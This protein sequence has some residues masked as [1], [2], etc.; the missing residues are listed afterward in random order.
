MSEHVKEKKSA[1]PE[2]IF[3][4]ITD[5]EKL[6]EMINRYVGGP[7]CLVLR[8][9]GISEEQFLNQFKCRFFN[10][11]KP[12]GEDGTYGIRHLLLITGPSIDYYLAI[13]ANFG[14]DIA[15]FV[16]SEKAF[17]LT[18]R[19]EV[20]EPENIFTVFDQRTALRTPSIYYFTE[21]S[22]ELHLNANCPLEYPYTELL[23][24][25]LRLKNITL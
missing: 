16:G 11:E 4:E 25:A 9:L 14:E 12:M 5:P 23:K 22:D 21:N 17:T 19:F 24:F 10:R 6:K 18:H 8:F 13:D 1:E 7:K 2:F 20:T 3:S 15:G